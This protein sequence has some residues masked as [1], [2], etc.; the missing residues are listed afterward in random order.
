LTTRLEDGRV[1]VQGQL[2]YKMAG[3]NH[4]L[5]L[6]KPEWAGEMDTEEDGFEKRGCRTPPRRSRVS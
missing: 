6:C 4:C 3:L 1:V 5:S 2:G